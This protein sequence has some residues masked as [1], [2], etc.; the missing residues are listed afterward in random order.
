MKHLLLASLFLSS[1]NIYA[2]LDDEYEHRYLC[3]SLNSNFKDSYILFNN[4]S[5]KAW[6]MAL[7]NYKDDMWKEVN[8]SNQPD[9]WVIETLNI[10]MLSIEIILPKKIPNFF[11]PDIFPATRV[12]TIID[13]KKNVDRRKTNVPCITNPIKPTIEDKSGRQAL[14]SFWMKSFQ[15]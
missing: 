8:L 15:N 14:R 4:D 7:E 10:D 3:L 11:L 2:Q 12:T 1:I 9:R 6:V 13:P 5:K